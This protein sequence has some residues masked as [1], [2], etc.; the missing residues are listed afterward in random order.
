[1]RFIYVQ[2]SIRNKVNENSS[3]LIDMQMKSVWPLQAIKRQFT[4]VMITNSYHGR[5]AANIY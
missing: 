1:M 5:D 4:Q 3:V 2:E